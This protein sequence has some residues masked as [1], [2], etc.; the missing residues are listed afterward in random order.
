MVNP[1]KP[2]EK[3]EGRWHY[4]DVQIDDILHLTTE[5]P[6]DPEVGTHWYNLEPKCLC[7]WD[8]VAWVHVPED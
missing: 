2:D 8:G 6:R 4:R 7:V 1:T 5:E 3:R